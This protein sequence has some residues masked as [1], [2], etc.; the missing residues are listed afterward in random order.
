MTTTITINVDLRSL[1]VI[2]SPP[3]G[4]DFYFMRIEHEVNDP[5]NTNLMFQH[6]HFSD[7]TVSDVKPS[8]DDCKS[9]FALITKQAQDKISAKTYMDD[10]LMRGA[11]GLVKEEDRV[12][13][14]LY[15]AI[16]DQ[17]SALKFQSFDSY[18]QYAGL[19]WPSFSQFK[20]IIATL[21]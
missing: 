7:K 14:K 20:Q 9:A 1:T 15:K 21:S 12:H 16:N 4:E 3:E 13:Y 5:S 2:P 8:I 6:Y 17:V 10:I 11:L 18:D 19:K